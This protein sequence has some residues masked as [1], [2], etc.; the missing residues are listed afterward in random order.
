MATLK[1]QCLAK[2]TG[3]QCEKPPSKKPGQDPR[4][5]W[6]HQPCPKQQLPTKDV[7]EANPKKIQA[8]EHLP[9]FD[10]VDEEVMGRVSHY[11]PDPDLVNLAQ[12]S[13]QM[14]T[15]T[16]SQITERKKWFKNRLVIFPQPHASFYSMKKGSPHEHYVKEDLDQV[17]LTDQD[18]FVPIYK[19]QLPQPSY[20]QETDQVNIA[21]TLTMKS[22]VSFRQSIEKIYQF[23]QLM[24]KSAQRD[25]SYEE[26]RPRVLLKISRD[27][28]RLLSYADLDQIIRDPQKVS[29][30]LYQEIIDLFQTGQ[31]TF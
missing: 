28:L 23:Y 2:S 4:Y 26:M 20:D 16:Q 11:L 27:T 31:V 19:I 1:C 12:T 5:C 29:P 21:E 24:Q 3:R 10:F 14:K 17:I 13:Q 22:P 15:R 30:Q 7:S 25:F 8:H 9:L 6:H 18:G